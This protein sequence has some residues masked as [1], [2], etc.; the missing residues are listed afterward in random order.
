V[1]IEAKKARDGIFAVATNQTQ[2]GIGVG[3]DA[4]DPGA[5]S[6][7]PVDAF[8]PVG[9]AQAHAVGDGEVEDS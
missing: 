4:G 3:E 8:Q 1:Q 9:G 6:Q 5:S 7:F 2:A